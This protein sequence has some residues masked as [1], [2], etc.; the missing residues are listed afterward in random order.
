MSKKARPIQSVYIN[1]ELSWLK[2]NERVL[3]EAAD[4][5][6]PLFERLKYIWIFMN[7][8]DEFFMIRVGSLQDQMLIKGAPPDNKTGMT[9]REQVAAVMKHARRSII[10][11]DVIYHA[12]IKKLAKYNIRRMSMAELNAQEEEYIHAYYMREIYPLLSPQIIDNRH[13]FPFLVNKGIYIGVYFESHH[14]TTFGIIPAMGAFNRMVMLP[15]HGMNFV[16]AED[17]IFHYANMMFGSHDLLDK[18]IFRVTRNA[19]IITDS[20]MFDEDTDFRFTMK[21]LL[22]KRVKLAPV[23]LEI[24]GELKKEFIRYICKKLLLDQSHVFMTGSPLDISYVPR[25]EDM[26]TLALRERLLFE[27]LVQ[28]EPVCIKAGSMIAQAL[29]RDILFAYPY[30]SMRHFIRMLYEAAGDSDVVSIKMTLYRV[31]KESEIIRSLIRAAENG[32][33]VI[34]VVELRARFDEEDNIEWATRLSEAG[35]RVIYGVEECKVH[36]K[37][38]L[39]TR[40][41]DK[42]IQYITQIGTGNYNER[43]AR[44]YTDLS[45]I[46]ANPEIGLDAVVLFNDILVNNINGRYNR[47]IVAPASMRRTILQMIQ[48]EMDC[49]M[50]KEP[51]SIFAKFNSLTDKD[52][53]DK[54]VEASSAGVRIRLIVRGICCLRPGIPGRTHNITVISIVGR[55]LEHARVYCFG[56]GARRRVFISSADWMTR[57]TERRIEVACPVLD[58]AIADR[59]L[60]M[61]E[62]GFCDNV[63]ARELLPDGTYIRKKPAEGEDL[64]NSQLYLFRN[65]LPPMQRTSL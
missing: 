42:S 52:I 13:T 30:E 59:I 51:A 11:K 29:E 46:T 2:F 5:D 34:I 54:L 36:S 60:E 3:E 14:D 22:K 23:R 58:T 1:R 12:C 39:I 53:I 16:L 49:A 4:P 44:Q 31:G 24:Q 50:R 17:I 38:L 33:D 35:C 45:L 26:L 15:G 10:R 18:M 25:L 28:Q 21:E 55:F 7:N 56:E 6:V 47:L 20:T 9:A 48:E 32:K 62:I 43:T 65:M 41:T 19:D 61:M 63:K 64:Q 27:P 37:V 57:N 8:M 40:K